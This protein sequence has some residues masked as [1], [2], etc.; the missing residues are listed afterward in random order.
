MDR[1]PRYDRHY[2]LAGFGP[3][4][5]EKL[6]Q[7]AV[8]VV[9]AGGLGCPVLQYLVAAGVGRIGI[10]DHDTIAI[11]NLQ[12]QVLFATG[13]I[14]LSKAETA[15]RK[16]RD[17]N[18]EVA[19]EA[20]AVRLSAANAAGLVADYDVVVDCTDNFTTR[21]LLGDCCRLLDKP[22]VF[23]AIFRYE[24]QVAVFNVAGPDGVKT[25]YRHLFPTPP[26]AADAP[27][28]NTAGVLGVLPGTIGTLQATEVI[29]I[30]TGTGEPLYNRLMTINLLDYTTLILDIPSRI[31]GPPDGIPG[32]IGELEMMDYGTYC[33]AEVP[34]GIGTIGSGRFNGIAASEDT[35]VIDVRNPDELPRLSTPHTVIPLPEL[36][37]YA[38]H[39]DRPNIVVVCQSGKRSL[40]AATLLRKKLD[41]TYTISHLEGG[42]ASLQQI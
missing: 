34:A 4:A 11:S 9:G 22:L 5:Q 35:L 41:N 12:R 8:L 40:T 32:T 26:G 37:A 10:V 6:E 39:F 16:L 30:I 27:D 38:G 15:A 29:K 21:Y 36:E 33:A 13:E 7:A 18:P 20:Y 3:A 19:I 1:N 2:Q 23:G 42:I 31:T 24:G 28:C 14:G 25:T 17:L